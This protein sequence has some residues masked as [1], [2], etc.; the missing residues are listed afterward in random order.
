MNCSSTVIRHLLS[1]T[2]W[3]LC[4]VV[5]CL[6]CSQ[7]SLHAHAFCWLFY[8][9]CSGQYFMLCTSIE[10]WDWVVIANRM[11]ILGNLGDS[12]SCRACTGAKTSLRVFQICMVNNDLMS[13]WFILLLLLPP[14]WYL[15][16]IFSILQVWSLSNTLHHTC[17]EIMRHLHTNGKPSFQGPWI[18][19]F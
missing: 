11:R 13:F 6:S 9:V 7:E 4:H 10:I 12:G 16:D 15:G 1:K 2:K 14:W 19:R 5:N 8:Q 17:C 3:H 18:C